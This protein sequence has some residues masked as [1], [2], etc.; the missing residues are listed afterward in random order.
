[1]I[2]D[3]ITL[4]ELL[5]RGLPFTGRS[6]KTP[7]RW[8]TWYYEKTSQ[9]QGNIHV[10]TDVKTSCLLQFKCIQGKWCYVY[11]LEFP[12]SNYST[13][14]R[15]V[16]W[17]LLSYQFIYFYKRSFPQSN[18][19]YTSTDDRSMKSFLYRRTGKFDYPRRRGAK[20]TFLFP[21]TS[22]KKSEK[23]WN[24]NFQNGKVKKKAG[25]HFSN[26][27]KILTDSNEG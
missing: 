10:R 2:S 6:W 19:H 15:I 12:L 8:T 20:Y 1:M 24:L 26:W 5:S 13:V 16:N 11:G 27:V 22:E 14:D 18:V 25:W 7:A 17:P 3:P 9:T 23:K 21:S 4:T